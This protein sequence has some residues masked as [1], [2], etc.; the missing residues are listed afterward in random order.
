MFPSTHIFVL[1][2]YIAWWWQVRPKHVALT[3]EF[4][5]SF[6]CLVAVLVVH[7]PILMLPSNPVTVESLHSYDTLKSLFSFGATLAYE[8]HILSACVPNIW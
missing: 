3:D 6:L 2:R 4:N 7:I 5:K 8:L 1:N